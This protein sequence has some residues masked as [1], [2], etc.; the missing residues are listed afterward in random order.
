MSICRCKDAECDAAFIHILSTDRLAQ[1][2]LQHSSTAIITAY[3]Y[4]RTFRKL[5]HDT[6][7]PP[8]VSFGVGSE[9]EKY[10]FPTGIHTSVGYVKD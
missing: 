2:S 4:F 10:R 1:A 5:P 6:P 3:R 9:V 8:L 7:Q